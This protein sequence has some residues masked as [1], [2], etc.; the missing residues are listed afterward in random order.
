VMTNNS[1]FESVKVNP[2]Q[3][4][5]FGELKATLL[6]PDMIVS[7]LDPCDPHAL[8]TNVVLP[9]ENEDG[10]TIPIPTLILPE[11]PARNS[12]TSNLLGEFRADVCK[13]ARNWLG[14]SSGSRTRY[15]VVKDG[16]LEIFKKN[17]A[18][19]K[20]SKTM[21]LEQIDTITSNL[22]DNGGRKGNF[23][24]IKGRDGNLTLSCDTSELLKK[25]VRACICYTVLIILAKMNFEITYNCNTGASDIYPLLIQG[26]R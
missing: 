22:G 6:A 1:P 24:T 3:F 10:V 14:S 7:R 9:I 20:A 18:G 4:I 16:K 2:Y 5:E 17:Q 11:N 15:L 13:K 23:F 25:C 8:E 12:G 19:A 21:K 26:P